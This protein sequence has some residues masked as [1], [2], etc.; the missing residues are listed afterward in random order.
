MPRTKNFDPAE[1]LEKAKNLFW[2]KGYYATSMQDLVDTLGINRA[3]MYD[4][5]GGK[6]QLFARALESYQQAETKEVSAILYYYTNVREG[7]YIMFEYM[8]NQALKEGF[9]HSCFHVNTVVELSNSSEDVKAKLLAAKEMYLKMYRTYL[10]YGK[11]KSQ[12]AA[13][14]NVEAIAQALYAFQCGLL[15]SSKLNPSKEN[16][17]KS[18]SAFLNLLD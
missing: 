18:V 8:L 5:Y 6:D 12:L 14:K 7:L 16:L 1:V 17:M 2:E 9:S 13:H 11:S 3:S 10:E 4:T 15:A